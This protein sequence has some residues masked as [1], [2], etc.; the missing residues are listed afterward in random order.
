[1][2]ALPALAFVLA[3]AT[4]QDEAPAVSPARWTQAEL[5][6]LSAEIAE[7]VADL[8][9]WDFKEAVAVRVTDA[10]GFLRYAKERGERMSSKEQER[11]DETV[12]KLL[13][14]LAPEYDL[15]KESEKLLASQVG[16]FYDP[17]ADTFYLMDRFTGGVAKVILAHELTHAL[18]DQHFDLDAG[19]ARAIGLGTD[20]GFA[21]AAV[22]E[23][24]GTQAMQQWAVGN[25][26]QLSLQDLEQAGSMGAAELAAAPPYLWKPLIAAYLQGQQFLA[27]GRK[28]PDAVRRAFEHP[29]RSSEQVLHP[30]KYWQAEQRDEPLAL[31]F[32]LARVKDWQ[33]L[34]QDTLGELVLALA[35]T[36]GAERK[37]LDISDAVGLMATQ[38]T[39]DAARGWGGDRLLLL[40]RG[41]ERRLQLVTAWDSEGDAR[42]FA[43]A[44]EAILAAQIPAGR[45]RSGATWRPGLTPTGFRVTADTGAGPFAARTIVVSVVSSTAAAAGEQDAWLA[46]AALVPWT[47]QAPG[48]R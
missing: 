3:S 8:R 43:A 41:E 32:E 31:A 1:M 30:E 17:G 46:A 29:P 33:V 22:V 16:G 13:G 28:V 4:V 6:E 35:A 20:A 44:M 47:V 12:A 40:G 18:D 24:S 7:E 23:G 37:G 21:Y 10:A 19:I 2:H 42:E 11:R 45:P 48:A 39:N 14:L 26:S 9:G 27:G 34:G 38:Y 15:E 25:A 5:E 36:P